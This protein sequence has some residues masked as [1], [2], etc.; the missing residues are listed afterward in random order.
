[1]GEIDIENVEVPASYLS[2]L[3]KYLEVGSRPRPAH[4]CS[5]LPENSYSLAHAHTCSLA[6]AQAPALAP[7]LAC[8]KDP[9]SGLRPGLCWAGASRRG[10]S[11]LW[12]RGATGE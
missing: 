12:L 2:S 11:S 9:V 3:D 5:Y 6:P 1:M 10:T 8:V 7:A 4:T